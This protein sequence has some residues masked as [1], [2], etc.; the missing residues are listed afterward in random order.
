MKALPGTLQIPAEKIHIINN[1]TYFN[2]DIMFYGT[3]SLEQDGSTWWVQGPLKFDSA[4]QKFTIKN[5][6]N[7]LDFTYEPSKIQ[8]F[9]ILHEYPDEIQHLTDNIIKNTDSNYF[10]ILSSVIDP[11]TGIACEYISET[12]LKNNVLNIIQNRT[13]ESRDYRYNSQTS[14]IEIVEI[15]G[16]YTFYNDK[17]LIK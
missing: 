11:N 8:G 7:N 12:L 2:N 16:L 6:H 5:M 10:N 13:F 1:E 14:G 15:S 3:Y 17:L 9:D 4:N